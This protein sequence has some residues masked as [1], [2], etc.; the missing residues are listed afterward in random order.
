MK[1]YNSTISSA[2]AVGVEGTTFYRIPL[3]AIVDYYS[4]SSDISRIMILGALETY[5]WNAFNI[6]S[7]Y[8]SIVDE[9]VLYL[10]ITDL[11][12]ISVN[13]E[14]VDPEDALTS[15][16]YDIDDLSSYIEDGNDDIISKYLTEYE[17]DAD[18]WDIDEVADECLKSEVFSDVVASAMDL[19]LFA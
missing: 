18:N 1:I 4:K 11:D 8:G 5:G 7:L 14:Q 9:D 6:K 12:T 3:E 15:G 19:D 16:R 17:L 13:G 2:A 10:C